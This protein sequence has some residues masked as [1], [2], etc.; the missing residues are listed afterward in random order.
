MR[1]AGDSPALGY[2]MPLYVQDAAMWASTVIKAR[3]GNNYQELLVLVI[4]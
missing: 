1:Q 3:E 4:S 2:M